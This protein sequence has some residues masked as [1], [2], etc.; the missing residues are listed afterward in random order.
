MAAE[1]FD[2]ALAL[3]LLGGRIG[4]TWNRCSIVSLCDRNSPRKSSDSVSFTKTLK[5]FTSVSSVR[6][7][8]F[9]LPE[10]CIAARNSAFFESRRALSSAAFGLSLPEPEG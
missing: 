9:A 1:V 2:G 6:W 5:K 3:G 8:C 4:I 10:L 7:W